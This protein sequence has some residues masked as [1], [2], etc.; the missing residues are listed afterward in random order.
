MGRNIERKGE[1]A[2]TLMKKATDRQMDRQVG[3]QIDGLTH[4]LHKH[5]F[6]GGGR[7]VYIFF[8][9]VRGGGEYNKQT[10]INK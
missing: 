3:I 4:I 1:I 7:G 2:L 8:F 5:I 6:W 9:L 10:Q